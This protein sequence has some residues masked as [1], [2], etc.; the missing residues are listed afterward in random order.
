MAAMTTTKRTVNLLLGLLVSCLICLLC[1]QTAFA[2]SLITKRF[3]DVRNDWYTAEVQWAVDDGV[4]GGY[5]NT[6]RFGV[7]DNLTRAQFA[8]IMAKA[9]GM[10]DAQLASRTDTTGKDDLKHGGQWYTGAC[11]WAVEKGIITGYSGSNDF[12][13]DDFVSREMAATIICRWAESQGADVSA[14]SSQA[15]S[16][17]DWNSVSDWAQPSIAWA[18]LAGVVTG[19]NR[20]DGTKWIEPSRNVLREEVCKM[21]HKAAIAVGKASNSPEISG[22]VFLDGNWYHFNEDG[23]AS[24][25][26]QI[27]DGVDYWFDASG[28]L[29]ANGWQQID[30]DRYY[31]GD[32][33]IMKNG[34][35]WD[36]GHWYYLDAWTGIMKTGL[37][38]IDG[39][40][41]GFDDSGAMTTGWQ[42]FDG[43]WYYFGDDGAAYT[44]SHTIDG[45]RYAF[46]QDGILVRSGVAT[47]DEEMKYDVAALC[48]QTVLEQAKIPSSVRIERAYCI[49]ENG[50]GYPTV[51]LECSA[52]NQLGGLGVI[53]SSALL[54]T[55]SQY[56][57]SNS[58]YATQ[59]WSYKSGAYY[60]VCYLS[61]GKQVNNYEG[62]DRM[63][64]SKIY[65]THSAYGF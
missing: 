36:G 6:D 24:I 40:Y 50:A 3:S 48:Y 35:L 38:K 9:S 54:E 16:M 23:S 10:T 57:P 63:D 45:T 20:A 18:N 61:N 7:G 55:A 34:W 39:K 22:W 25:G 27:I 26:W 46:N 58:S 32:N 41:Y 21:V 14:T 49:D 53:Y 33:G 1:T 62:Y 37:Q 11:N 59:V 8:K 2:G 51:R 47:W 44:G 19:A 31:F 42:Q 4:M 43:F 60:I 30:G 28:A 65:A 5:A 17:P 13:P 64:I 56:N 29:A 52:A 15:S 12:R